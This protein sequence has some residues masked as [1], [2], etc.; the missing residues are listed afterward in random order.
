LAQGSEFSQLDYGVYAESSN[1]S[2]PY[3]VTECNFNKNFSGIF[4]QGVLS[5]TMT[6][7]VFEVYKVPASG[8]FVSETIGI[9]FIGCNRY[10]VEENIFMDG[11]PSYQ[12]N[13]HNYG[14]EV[15]SSGLN[16]NV[17]EN[18]Q[19]A[20]L[21]SG[22][23]SR[24]VNASNYLL[25]DTQLR[26]LQWLC[27]SFQNMRNNDLWVRS[28]R[29]APWQGE[30]TSLN[31]S[32]AGNKF[33]PVSPSGH[34]H[35]RL[36]AASP[37]IRY[38][39]FNEL[40]AMPTSISP[41]VQLWQCQAEEYIR[42]C[43][44]LIKVDETGLN[45]AGL[46]ELRD[47]L[48]NQ[49]TTIQAVIDFG[50]TDSLVQQVLL[51]YLSDEEKRDLLKNNDIVVSDEVII[52]YMESNPP[53]NMLYQVLVHNSPLSPKL[54]HNLMQESSLPSGMKQQ[55]LLIQN[56]LSDYESKMQY[57]QYLNL[58][59]QTVE[60][61]IMQIYLED[62]T[63]LYTTEDF[64]NLF[65]QKPHHEF[66]ELQELFTAY[67][68]ARDVIK[69]DSINSLLKQL[70]TDLEFSILSDLALN[71]ITSD[72][73]SVLHNDSALVTQ[74]ENMATLL[75]HQYGPQARAILTGVLGYTFSYPLE[76]PIE[77]R[78]QLNFDITYDGSVLETVSLFPN[79]AQDHFFI[80]FDE[81]ADVSQNR[82]V[83]VYDLSGVLQFTREMKANDYVLEIKTENMAKGMY[84]VTIS[85]NGK[86]ISMQK[87]AVR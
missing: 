8:L 75:D 63:E 82:E 60:N 22:G 26:G 46:V 29:I 67:L 28:G 69:A 77:P 45:P 80:V 81:N 16:S 53:A 5:A 43:G 37:P 55:V 24:G 76:D 57:L 1:S 87:V 38:Y 36:S 70:N 35:Y 33:S 71:S 50:A 83:N 64:K 62:S 47:S 13:A 59:I 61:K 4:A 10:I 7:N 15:R 27:N 19:F 20:G 44:R 42:V 49:K 65:E 68:Y 85:A 48:I 86:D 21:H 79:P 14:I 39:Y 9:R 54:I 11:M 3:T 25:P 51:P 73:F 74:L 66:S 31:T 41:T 34:F 32:P 52:R 84:L 40:H 23:I 58:E 56:G 30:C 2:L 12:V 72:Y 17:I 18:N 6:K 78:N